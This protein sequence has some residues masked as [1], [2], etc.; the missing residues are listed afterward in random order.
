MSF[1]RPIGRFSA[2]LEVK[3]ASIRAPSTAAMEP[4]VA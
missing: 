1:R 3:A 4:V 2:V